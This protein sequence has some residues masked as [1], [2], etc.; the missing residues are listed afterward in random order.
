MVT[1]FLLLALMFSVPAFAGQR[2]LDIETERSRLKGI[3]L[4]AAEIADLQTRGWRDRRTGEFEPPVAETM[5]PSDYTTE[6]HRGTLEFSSKWRNY[7]YHLIKIPDGTIVTERN[8]AQIAPVTDAFDKTAG[9][10]N[11]L[12]FN[13]CNLVNVKSYPDWTISRGNTAQIDFYLETNPDTGEDEMKGQFAASNSDDVN[14]LRV[15]PARVVE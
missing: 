1:V 11:N 5:R 3:T 7:S 2:E 14:P 10:G 15:K 12:V 6:F 4:R 13:D 9:F 8:F